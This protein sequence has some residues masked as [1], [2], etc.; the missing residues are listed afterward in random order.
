MGLERAFGRS[1]HKATAITHSYGTRRRSSPAGDN[2][3]LGRSRSTR[4]LQADPQASKLASSDDNSIQGKERGH[5]ENRPP[6]QD[7]LAV[8]SIDL[9]L[10][11]AS[12]LL[13]E[14]LFLT[15]FPQPNNQVSSSSLGRICSRVD[16]PGLPRRVCQGP[17]EQGGPQPVL[18]YFPPLIAGNISLTMVI[19]AGPTS[20]TK[21]AGKMKMTS[22]KIN[23]T[24]VLAAFSSAICRRRVLIES[25]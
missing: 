7:H 14:P 21:I 1:R 12:L 19:A 3:K 5:K 13:L 11:G 16:L 9:W 6:R 2:Q 23:L 18:D 17:F 4:Q 24:A 10:P 22:G 20:T 8:E 15:Q 25:L